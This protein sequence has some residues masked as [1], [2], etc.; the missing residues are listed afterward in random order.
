[1]NYVL[2]ILFVITNAA[3]TGAVVKEAQGTDAY[4]EPTMKFKLG[5]PV[6]ISM[7]TAEIFLIA[8]GIKRLVE[9]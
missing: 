5:I 2:A 4:G 7:L 8:N 3:V 9:L 1:M 6:V